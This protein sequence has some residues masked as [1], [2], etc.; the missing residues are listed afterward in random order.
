MENET[1]NA[2]IKILYAFNAFFKWDNLSELFNFNC[3]HGL[4]RVRGDCGQ[5]RTVTGL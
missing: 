4:K 1:K 2:D 3:L 5:G